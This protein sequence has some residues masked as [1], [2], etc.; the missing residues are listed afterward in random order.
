MSAILYSEVLWHSKYF[1]IQVL[2]KPHWNVLK[3]W[4]SALLRTGFVKLTTESSFLFL[5]VLKPFAYVWETY[6]LITAARVKKK[7][8]S[9]EFREHKISHFHKI[10]KNELCGVCSAYGGWGEAYTVFWWGNLKEI[11][12]FGDTGVDGRII[13]RWIIRKWDVGIW[14]E[15]SWLRMGRGGEHLWLR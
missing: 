10:D 1:R 13:L 9:C 8:K 2:G 4:R 12:H 14:T 15:S 3:Q 5:S 6:L 11:D 7:R